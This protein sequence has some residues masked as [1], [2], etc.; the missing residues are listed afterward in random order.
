MM[1]TSFPSRAAQVIGKGALIAALVYVV[2]F[3]GFVGGLVGGGLINLLV[4]SLP[5]EPVL[6]KI[7]VPLNLLFAAVVAM[8][9]STLAWLAFERL[10]WRGR[11]IQIACATFLT[12]FGFGL[13]VGLFAFLQFVD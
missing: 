7:P 11:L 5:S 8:G 10:Y 6:L 4:S 1:W 13:G 2:A 9:F 12:A 3:L